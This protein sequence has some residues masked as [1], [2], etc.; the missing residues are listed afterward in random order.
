MSGVAVDYDMT[1]RSSR[2]ATLFASICTMSLRQPTLRRLR[3]EPLEDR[4]M[5]SVSFDLLKDINVENSASS[6]PSQFTVLGEYVYYTADDGV[7]GIELWRSNGT[8]AGTSLVK[9]IHPGQF[10]FSTSDAP[11]ASTV[12][13]GALY[14]VAD[15]G[16][17]GREVWRSDG[18]EAG[19]VMLKDIW[20][21]GESSSP[22]SFA[23]YQGELY[24]TAATP[25]LGAELW[26]TD[27]SL[28]GTVLALDLAGEEESIPFN[29]T[30]AGDKLFFTAQTDDNSSRYLWVSDG[31]A[32]NTTQL[33]NIA[34]RSPTL[35]TAVGDELY[36]YQTT[37]FS[38][39]PFWLAKS[40]GTEQ[41]TQRIADFRLRPRMFTAYNNELYFLGYNDDSAIRYSLYHSDG[42]TDGTVPIK[43]IAS[44]LSG[45]AAVDAE[46]I[47]DLL[48]FI[49][50]TSSTVQTRLWRSD[51]TADGTFVLPTFNVAPDSLPVQLGETLYFI[52]ARS[53]WTTDGT[54]EGTAA[55]VTGLSQS[56]PYPLLFIATGERLFFVGNGGRFGVEL[57]TSDGTAAGTKVVA[58][59]NIL[60]T[61]D[62]FPNDFVELNDKLYFLARSGDNSNTQELWNTDG[63][64]EG[65][66]RVRDIATAVPGT[67]VSNNSV[68][69]LT[70][71]GDKLLLTV[72]SGP[73]GFEL[74]ESD[75][76]EVG[77]K[78]LKVLTP[79]LGGLAFGRPAFFQQAG[80]LMYWIGPQDPNNGNS[81]LWR[82]DGTADGTFPLRNPESE[83]DRLVG[84]SYT[85]VGNLLYFRGDDGV[86]GFELWRTD[87]TNAGTYRVKDINP[88]SADSAIVSLSSNSPPPAMTVVGNLLFFFA[89][90]GQSGL[91]LWRS[92]GTEEGTYRVRDIYGGEESSSFSPPGGIAF[93]G[94]FY[95]A[96]DDGEHGVELWKSDGTEAG[97]TLVEDLMPLASDAIPRSFT[98]I[99]ETFYYVANDPTYGS[100]IR[101]LTSASSQLVADIQQVGFQG[102]FGLTNV[103]GTLYFTSRDGV[104]G[105][106]LYRTDGTPEGTHMVF[107]SSGAD[108]DSFPRDVFLYHDDLYFTVENETYGRE[109]FVSRAVLAGDYNGDALVDHLDFARW[110]SETVAPIDLSADGNND[111]SISLGDYTVWR[112]NLGGTAPALTQPMRGDY[113]VNNQFDETD[114]ELW[115]STFGSTLGLA[116]DGNGDG[117]VNLADYTV[118]RDRLATGAPELQIAS[119]ANLVAASIT[120]SEEPLPVA[121]SLAGL[122]SPHAPQNTLHPPLVDSLFEHSSD[123][124]LLLLAASRSTCVETVG[125]N[126]PELAGGVEA[127]ADRLQASLLPMDAAF[128][129]ISL[130]L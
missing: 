62:A 116:A 113:Q 16:V 36:Y 76:T 69:S 30:V 25:E 81:S 67:P 65:T 45:S 128:E 79:G 20:P 87:G 33:T 22:H 23:E 115:K 19:T 31:T 17:H 77:T 40:D 130:D 83:G 110:Q 90:D 94:E 124:L 38:G 72:K 56:S 21:E 99:G 117:T 104:S 125:N 51:G 2:T 48:Y 71:L 74:W 111:G 123:D 93:E 105:A 122:M 63:T 11:S 47:D 126:Q 66:H 27:G 6:G 3:V 64:E 95:F 46:V 4:R 114:Y 43:R 89:D 118:W 18:T 86:S 70:K 84:R 75:G 92:N 80:D 88:G 37:T 101:K 29:L 58:D 109:L 49:S 24:F 98:V 15:D 44:S 82:T 55:A 5:L 54:I 121:L 102:P 42:T 96:A 50:P 120:Q 7:H 10:P 53:L 78:L 100:E 41:G 59:V 57:W 32:E 119:A 8:Q 12:Y 28:E 52:H 60:P 9:D 39:I 108:E 91:E 34:A 129:S 68:L 61:R 14:F 127:Y 97:T 107:D 26:K 35:L 73:S 103:E 1:L 106:E 112:D 85:A 13:N